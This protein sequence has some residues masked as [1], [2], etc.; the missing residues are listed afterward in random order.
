M[1]LKNDMQEYVTRIA[2]QAAEATNAIAFF[3]GLHDKAEVDRNHLIAL[4]SLAGRKGKLVG[5]VEHG[6]EADRTTIDFGG[7]RQV[8]YPNSI[9]VHVSLTRRECI[10]PRRWCQMT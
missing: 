7:N 5:F 3:G 8:G 1:I 2:V 10:C 4:S 6:L 9:L